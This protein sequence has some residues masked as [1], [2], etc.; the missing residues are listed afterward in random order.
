MILETQ[1]SIPVGIKGA[2]LTDK[3]IAGEEESET[4]TEGTEVAETDVEM[5]D[6]GA[7]EPEDW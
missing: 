5:L 2:G 7:T 1:P 3:D 4:A 6:E